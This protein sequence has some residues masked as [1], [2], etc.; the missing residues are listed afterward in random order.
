MSSIDIAPTVLRLAGL[1][2]PSSFQGQNFAPCLENPEVKIRSYAFAESNWHDFDDHARAVMDGRFKYIRNHY[3]DIMRTPG[4]DAIRSPTFQAMRKLRDAGKLTPAQMA[5]FVKPR[6]AE[7][8]Y[9]T[10]ADPH[11]I[12]NLASDPAHSKMLRRLREALEFWE[13]ETGD[14]VPMKRTP[15]EFDRETGAPLPIRV[16][17]RIPRKKRPENR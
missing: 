5:C 8:L 13:K 10:Q 17:P 7:E 1:P 11:E 3:D 6:P 4:A 12:K 9:D 2:V 16:R 15:D 14:F